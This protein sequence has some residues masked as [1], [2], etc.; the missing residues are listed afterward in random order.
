M[1]TRASGEEQEVFSQTQ[2]EAARD[3]LFQTI[4]PHSQKPYFKYIP[5]LAGVFTNK[6]IT[7]LTT[8]KNYLCSRNK[9]KL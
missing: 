8:Q 7:R 6:Q 2:W 3:A 1:K 5:A 9:Y 4:L